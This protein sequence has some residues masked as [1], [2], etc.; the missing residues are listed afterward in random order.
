MGFRIRP[1][2]PQDF[3]TLFH[4]DQACFPPGIAYPRSE[5]RRFLNLSGS[6]AWVAE[7]G[8]ET[9]GFLIACL[10]S[11][12]IV[13]IVTIDV[14][15]A[16]RRKGIGGALMNIAEEWGRKRQAFL[17]YLET[18]EENVVAHKFYKARGYSIVERVDGYYSDGTAAWIMAKSLKSR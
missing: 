14:V 9:V 7:S 4:I 3:E 10:E 11:K 1:Y 13:H 15:D 16:W 12:K 18:G 5:L 17:L 8:N 2:R 6:C